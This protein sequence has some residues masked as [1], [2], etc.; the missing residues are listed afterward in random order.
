MRRLLIAWLAFGMV[1]SAE[2]Q[3][4]GIDFDY[5]RRSIVLSRSYAPKDGY[6]PDASTAIAIADAVTVPIYGRSTVDQEKP[7]RAE[8]KDGR[9]LVIGTDHRATAGGGGTVEVLIDQMTAK[10]LYLNHSM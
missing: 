1:A 9:W 4:P 6:V 2:P 5:V 10:I 3:R 8:L 7:L